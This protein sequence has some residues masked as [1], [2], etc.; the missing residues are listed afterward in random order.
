VEYQGHG[1]YQERS[2]MRDAIKRE[3]VRKAKV[4]FLEVPAEYTASKQFDD[5]PLCFC[6][7]FDVAL[8]GAECAMASEHLYIT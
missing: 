1:H 4:A 3:A 6:V 7:S 5:P 8:C 2:F